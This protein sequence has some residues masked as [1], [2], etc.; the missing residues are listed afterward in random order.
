M[1]CFFNF[2]HVFASYSAARKPDNMLSCVVN[3]IILR[4]EYNANS[5]VTEDCDLR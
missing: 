5:F 4:T 3:T 2:L 1:P